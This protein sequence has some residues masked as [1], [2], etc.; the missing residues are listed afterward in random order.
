MALNFLGGLNAPVTKPTGH[1]PFATFTD[2]LKSGA[3]NYRGLPIP[4]DTRPAFAGGGRGPRALLTKPIDHAPA[5]R[6]DL[7]LPFTTVVYNANAIHVPDIESIGSIGAKRKLDRYRRARAEAYVPRGKTGLATLLDS[8]IT[9][10]EARVQEKTAAMTAQGHL[11]ATIAGAIAEDQRILRDLYARR[12]QAD[13]GINPAH[14]N[15]MGLLQKNMTVPIEVSEDIRVRYERASAAGLQGTGGRPFASFYTGAVM[16]AAMRNAVLAGLP[17]FH[18]EAGENNVDINADAGLELRPGPMAPA[19]ANGVQDGLAQPSGDAIGVFP[20]PPGQAF[21]DRVGA[22]PTLN[23]LEKDVL[24]T[25]YERGNLALADLSDEELRLAAR[26]YA[27]AVEAARAEGGGAGAGAGAGAL[28]DDDDSGAIVPMTPEKP[29]GPKFVPSPETEELKGLVKERTKTFDQSMEE[30][31][32][33]YERSGKVTY[34]RPEGEGAEEKR[35]LVTDGMLGLMRA[36]LMT[37]GTAW[38]TRPPVTSDFLDP[39]TA[40]GRTTRAKLL[41]KIFN[42][43]ITYQNVLRQPAA[44]PDR[45][46]YAKLFQEMQAAGTAQFEA[47]KA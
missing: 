39:A 47:K 16:N 22:D 40:Q 8:E 26:Q 14:M 37:L 30:A 33:P 18:A 6:S 28:M 45:E 17:G 42:R 44:G 36:Y 12:T 41:R 15:V 19:I 5:S 24:L 25:V 29:T 4:E 23:E 35:R 2:K 9:A 1:E 46:L 27:A 31:G 13:T 20:A 7:P 43:Y 3:Q 11:P 21:A 32:M 38:G 34:P 10:L